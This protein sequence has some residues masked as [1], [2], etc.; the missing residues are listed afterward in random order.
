MS[1]SVRSLKEYRR[2]QEEARRAIEE[3]LEEYEEIN[4]QAKYANIQNQAHIPLEVVKDCWEADNPKAAPSFVDKYWVWIVIAGLL[5][6]I[7]AGNLL[8]DL[9]VAL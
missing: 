4:F 2:H 3:G 5:A 1:T 9:V 8:S 7:I 6:L